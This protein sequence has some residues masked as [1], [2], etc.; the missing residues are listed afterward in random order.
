MVA[1]AKVGGGSDHMQK[2][3]SLRAINPYNP[4]LGMW[5]AT[6]RR[7]RWYDRPLHPEQAITRE[8]ALR[9]YTINNAWL[10]FRE[11][12]IGSI[13]PGKFADLVV[14]D[15]DLLKCSEDDLRDTEALRTYL[16]GKIV[17][18]RLPQNEP[19]MKGR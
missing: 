9:F 7:A 5:V 15:R 1:G 14:L 19:Q 4:F 10:L 6:T 2:I 16:A 11:N 3:G 17:H 13:E 18:D 12:E 8:Q